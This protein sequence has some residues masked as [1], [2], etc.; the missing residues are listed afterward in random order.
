MKPRLS[1]QSVLNGTGKGWKHWFA[2]LDKF[3]CKEKG[4]KEAAKFL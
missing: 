2:V 3:G 1:E 4:H